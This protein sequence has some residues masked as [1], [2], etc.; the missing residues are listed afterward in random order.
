LRKTVLSAE[1]AGNAKLVKLVIKL[2]NANRV[3][4]VQLKRHVAC[5]R[6]VV[7]KEMPWLDK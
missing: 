4:D 3:G 7:R 5:D 1:P 6:Q 2:E